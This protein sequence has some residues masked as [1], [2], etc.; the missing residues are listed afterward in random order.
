MFHVV[1]V[2]TLGRNLATSALPESPARV[3]HL[4]I[5]PVRVGASKVLRAW[6]RKLDPCA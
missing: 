5:G 1:D 3:P 2:T 6:A 4:A